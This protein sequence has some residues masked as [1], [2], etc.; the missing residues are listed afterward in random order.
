MLTGVGS[1]VAV[2]LIA[3]S[4]SAAPMQP[5]ARA[6]PLPQGNV[7]RPNLPASTPVQT[8]PIPAFN[9]LTAD[10]IAGITRVAQ[11]QLNALGYGPLTVDGI[12]GEHTSSAI[13]QFLVDYPPTQDQHAAYDSLT[14]GRAEL[15]ELD[16]VIRLGGGFPAGAMPSSGLFSAAR[17][18]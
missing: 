8:R 12:L 18:A 10:Q 16:D 15:Y 1:V 14:D 11:A 7:P 3:R 17:F 4:A 9:T 2:D 6:T 5:A 13:Q